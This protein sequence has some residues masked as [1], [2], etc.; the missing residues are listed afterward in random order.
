MLLPNMRINLEEQRAIVLVSEPASDGADIDAG[1][2]AS[3]PE[4]VTQGMGGEPSNSK[5][6]AGARDE[7]L[8]FFDE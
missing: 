7:P 4:K 1:F 6:F 2:K 5:F 8:G 3:C